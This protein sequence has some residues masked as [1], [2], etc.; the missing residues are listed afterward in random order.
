MKTEIKSQP[1]VFRVGKNQ[2]IEISD[3]G[4]LFLTPDEMVTFV[5]ASKKRFD[6]VQKDW[7]FYATPSINSRLTKEGFHTALV[8][9]L[10]GQEYIMLVEKEMKEKFY[11]YCKSDGQIILT[12]LHNEEPSPCMCALPSFVDAVRYSTP[13]LGE[14]NFQI[15]KHEYN[16]SLIHI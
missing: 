6:I 8:R 14:T 9:N 2:Q 15:S 3:F 13:P 12:W 16:L 5:T 1:R 11:E 10:A 7:G 4:Q